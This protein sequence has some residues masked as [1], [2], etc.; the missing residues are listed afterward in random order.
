M[1]KCP[2]CTEE[3]QDVAIKCRHCGEFLDS[4]KDKIEIKE[5]TITCPKCGQ[6]TNTKLP[7]ICKVCKEPL[8]NELVRTAEKIQLEYSEKTKVVIKSEALNKIEESGCAPAVIS[9]II[10]GTGQMVKGQVGK[11]IVYL[12]L[13]IGLGVISYGVLAI[14]IAI[15][16]CVDA[17]SSIYKCP[18]CK[19]V[20]DSN[21]TV[22]KYCQTKF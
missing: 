4:N 17:A 18:K 10:P 16:S 22:C 5:Y 7:Y 9:L 11:G 20:I 13:A 3:I 6:K 1:K 19:S 21:A 8:P 15:I 2:F 14:V 12:V